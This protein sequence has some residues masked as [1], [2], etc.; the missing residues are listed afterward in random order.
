M[1]EPKRQSP[2]PAP[3]PAVATKCRYRASRIDESAQAKAERSKGNQVKRKSPDR[4]KTIGPDKYLLNSRF[5]GCVRYQCRTRDSGRRDDGR[6]GDDVSI[7]KLSGLL[8]IVF[9]V[10][11]RQKFPEPS[12][13]MVKHSPSPH[14][15]ILYTRTLR[16]A[17]NTRRANAARISSPVSLAG[18]AGLAGR[19][20]WILRRYT[21]LNAARSFG[22]TAECWPLRLNLP[23]GL[24]PSSDSH[25]R[26]SSPCRECW[27]R[28]QPFVFV[29]LGRLGSAG[30]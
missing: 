7:L 5:N 28:R 25:P 17:A 10:V 21:G 30:S 1:P 4:S 19:Q 18:R 12:S 29:V 13:D 23:Q 20:T 9:F 11:H 3:P 8:L 16:P 24:I 14:G 26:F 2:V 27:L 15:R 6:R 22:N